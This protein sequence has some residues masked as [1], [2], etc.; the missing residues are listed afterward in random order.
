VNLPACFGLGKDG[1]AL[2]SALHPVDEFD[3]DGCRI[4]PENMAFPQADRA[5]RDAQREFIRNF[6]DD[7]AR[8]LGAA[9]RQVLYEALRKQI[10]IAVIDFSRRM[11][12]DSN[13]TST[14]AS[15]D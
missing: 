8:D 3:A 12:L 9:V 6:A 10:T 13:I 1:T 11:P 14:I 5:S 15:H 7:D 4:F 2:M